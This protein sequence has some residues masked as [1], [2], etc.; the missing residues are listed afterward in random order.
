MTRGVMVNPPAP[1]KATAGLAAKRARPLVPRIAPFQALI[2]AQVFTLVI[3]L[4]GSAPARAGK[5]DGLP[6]GVLSEVKIE[7]NLSVTSEKVRAKLL[8][9]VGSPL[10][11]RLID[12]DIK[13][14]NATKWFSD[15][16]PYYERD[17][18]DPSGK[19]YVLIFTVKEMPVLTHVD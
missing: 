4:I 13:S 3:V 7:G 2:L 12:T 5:K 18:R 6:D 8:S 11:A 17:K 19:S 1:G 10:D 15:V 16:T 9:K 14:L